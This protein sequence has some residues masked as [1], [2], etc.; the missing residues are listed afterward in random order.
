MVRD[1]NREAPVAPEDLYPLY[2]ATLRRIRAAVRG[3]DGE[4]LR[5]F[6]LEFGS[7]APHERHVA[8]MA[9]H[10]VAA[11]R[12]RLA[13]AH[14]VRALRA[15]PRDQYRSCLAAVFRSGF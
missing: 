10:D 14:F 9:V 1:V 6:E 8:A 15:E 12:P 2:L 11:G 13:K 3:G 7:F 4:M 5:R